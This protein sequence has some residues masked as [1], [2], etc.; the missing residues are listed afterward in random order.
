MSAEGAGHRCLQ[1]GHG[2]VVCRGGRAGH[3][4]PHRDALKHLVNRINPPDACLAPPTQSDALQEGAYALVEILLNI[5]RG[6]DDTFYTGNDED[7]CDPPRPIGQLTRPHEGPADPH[8]SHWLAVVLHVPVTPT[9]CPCHSHW[10][11][12]SLLLDVPITPTGC[13]YHPNG[14]LPGPISFTNSSMYATSYPYNG[15]STSVMWIQVCNG[16]QWKVPWPPHTEG[17]S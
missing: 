1:R 16:T 17:T 15:R 4:C 11:S 14:C 9:G 12:L 3:I 8:Q 7:V 10:M 6:M 2:T 5:N 13:P